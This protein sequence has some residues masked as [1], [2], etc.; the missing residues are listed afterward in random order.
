[1]LAVQGCDDLL[2]RNALEDHIGNIQL[3]Q[4]VGKQVGRFQNLRV[5]LIYRLS[6]GKMDEL[7]PRNQHRFFP[8][9][10]GNA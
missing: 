9:G 5:I 1:M 3:S 7:G 6:C 4:K 8:L 10:K 2:Q